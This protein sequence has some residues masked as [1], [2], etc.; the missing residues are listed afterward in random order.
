[1]RFHPSLARIRQSRPGTTDYDAFKVL[2]SELRMEVIGA[3]DGVPIMKFRYRNPRT[4]R[5]DDPVIWLRR[6]PSLFDN[7]DRLWPNI[8][9]NQNWFD[10]DYPLPEPMETEALSSALGRAM[11][12][13]AANPGK[14]NRQIA[15]EIGVGKDTVKRA[16]ELCVSDAPPAPL[17]APPVLPD[18]PLDAPPG[19]PPESTQPVPEPVPEPTPES[20][21]KP[22]PE[23]A[24]VDTPTPATPA[25]QAGPPHVHT[26]YAALTGYTDAIKRAS[27]TLA[28][29]TISVA[30]SQ[31]GI[32]SYGYAPLHDTQPPGPAPAPTVLLLPLDQILARII[33]RGE[34]TVL[35]PEMLPKIEQARKELTRAVSEECARAS[36][37]IACAK[38]ERRTP[39]ELREIVSRASSEDVFRIMGLP[40]T[41]LVYMLQDGWLRP[42]HVR[43]DNIA[44]VPE[45]VDRLWPARAAGPA[46]EETVELPT[47]SPAE[48]SETVSPTVP[49]ATSTPD[50]PASETPPVP[51]QPEALLPATPQHS[52]GRPPIQWHPEFD[53]RVTKGKAAGE[54]LESTAGAVIKLMSKI[55]G[56]DKDNL[57]A[58]TS[59]MNLISKSRVAGMSVTEWRARN[60]N[61][62]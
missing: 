40:T 8:E 29:K 5:I 25:M 11:A 47:P 14:F 27:E 57:P 51:E 58:V 48:N 33:S 56:I 45:G 53:T 59:V 34:T 35:S 36:A 20:V 32:R 6:D 17:D 9:C 43:W 46:T 31:S 13:V 21:P 16:R 22:A 18:A 49:D 41:E 15:Q 4:D 3:S 1:L 60:R 44:G 52:I 42:E 7:L 30:P 12:A 24:P 61:E 19:A 26:G 62:E 50:A 2:E 39:H 37:K 55:L 28:S 10:R 23:P 38:L 54:T